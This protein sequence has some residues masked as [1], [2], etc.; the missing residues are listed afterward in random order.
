MNTLV[1]PATQVLRPGTSGL[2]KAFFDSAIE[3]LSA[4]FYELPGQG[5]AAYLEHL[6]PTSILVPKPTVSKNMALYELVSRIKPS[7][8][9]DAPLPPPL[10]QLTDNLVS[11]VLILTGYPQTA[12][13]KIVDV[14]RQT[15]D[16]WKK[17]GVKG[18]RTDSKKAKAALEALRYTGRAFFR[19]GGPESVR[20]WL[21]WPDPDR[22]IDLLKLPDG[23]DL[24]EARVDESIY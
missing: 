1:A 2:K 16:N 6:L 20:A 19:R 8:E 7:D 13:E 12:L 22:P 3:G 11:D 9:V 5:V 15:L 17:N 4:T 10:P 18:S 23:P 14:K 24:L 21:E